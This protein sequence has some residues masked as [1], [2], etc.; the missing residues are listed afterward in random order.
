MD[1]S[2]PGSSLHGI[3]QTRTWEWAAMPFSRGSSPPRYRIRV[4][5][6][7]CIG[8]WVLSLLGHQG[9][10]GLLYFFSIEGEGTAGRDWL[11]DNAWEGRSSIKAGGL[12]YLGP[13]LS[14]PSQVTYWEHSEEP[15]KQA[16]FLVLSGT[17]LPLPTPDTIRKK[18]LH[19][20][21]RVLAA[22]GS[23]LLQVK[24]SYTPAP[25]RTKYWVSLAWHSSAL[26]IF[27]VLD[28]K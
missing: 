27:F 5:W 2:L 28:F 1:Y 6:V 13:D 25:V 22:S 10:P 24:N 3:L 15:A 14:G 16:W 21:C 11:V 17:G 4:S 19:R 12:C 9:N 26:G 18:S 20:E 8:R 23:D 7:F